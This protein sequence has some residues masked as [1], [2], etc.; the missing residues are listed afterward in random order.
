ML[1]S[2]ILLVLVGLWL[3]SMSLCYPHKK[4]FS[5]KMSKEKKRVFNSAGWL[6]LALALFGMCEVYGFGIGLCLWFGVIT[7][8]ST[9]LALSYSYM[10][11]GVFA[12]ES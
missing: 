9:L 10:P 1:V 6:A 11:K 3:S 5:C 8:F 2:S 12:K 4:I 7:L